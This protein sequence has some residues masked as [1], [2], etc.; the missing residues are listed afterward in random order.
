MLCSWFIACAVPLACQKRDHDHVMVGFLS[1]L[2]IYSQILIVLLVFAAC[3]PLT[4]K[5]SC[6][7][8]DC[9]CSLLIAELQS[10]P[11]TQAS[12]ARQA[13]SC[14]TRML[15]CSSTSSLQQ[16]SWCMSRYVAESS[17]CAGCVYRCEKLAA[18]LPQSQPGMVL[19]WH[20]A[21]CC[22]RPDLPQMADIC[23]APCRHG[24]AHVLGAHHH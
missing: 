13:Y 23:P 3:S 9:S 14:L 24:R 15:T 19:H 8:H 2:C 18:A 21:R 10:S 22:S 5:V 11:L 16:C 17:A 6:S 7:R 12:S 1:L 20:R 4:N